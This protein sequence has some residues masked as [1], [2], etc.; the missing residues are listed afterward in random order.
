M[1]APPSWVFPPETETWLSVEPISAVSPDTAAETPKALVF[2]GSVGVSFCCW[3][4]VEP[5]PVKT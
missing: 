3:L 4:Q 5:L 1:K 2:A